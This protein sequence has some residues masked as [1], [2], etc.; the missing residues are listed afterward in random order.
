MIGQFQKSAQKLRHSPTAPKLHT[1]QRKNEFMSHSLQNSTLLKF[2][3]KPRK[4]EKASKS[5]MNIPSPQCK[6]KFLRLVSI[7]KQREKSL[8]N[9][10]RTYNGSSDLSKSVLA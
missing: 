1:P 6:E 5:P 10:L 9:V 4:L 7:E 3:T 2:T 8:K